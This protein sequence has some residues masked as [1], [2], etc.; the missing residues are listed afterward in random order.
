MN[1]Q[2][3]T[4]PEQS[5][6]LIA[7]EVDPKSADMTWQTPITTSQKRIGEKILVLRHP[8]HQ[9]YVGDVPA[10]SLGRLLALLP[11]EIKTED[12]SYYDEIS[13][14][15][16]LIYPYMQGWQIDYQ[17]CE[18]DECHCLK[19]IHGFDLIEAC[20]KAI[21]WLTKEKSI[22]LTKY[23]NDATDLH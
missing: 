15:G 10:W 3:A 12:N 21:E 19:C 9:D 4:T 6:R 20:V 13:T 17:Y 5:K 16:L 11:T 22:N 2:I 8:N 18:D 23:Q 14:F 7:C 1:Q